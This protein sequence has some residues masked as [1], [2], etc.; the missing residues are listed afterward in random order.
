MIQNLAFL[1][2][3]HLSIDVPL[4]SLTIDTIQWLKLPMD[5]WSFS[6]NLMKNFPISGNLIEVNG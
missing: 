1:V 6:G 5:H 2:V 4:A 3:M